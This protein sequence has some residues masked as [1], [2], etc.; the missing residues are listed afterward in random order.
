MFRVDKK[1]LTDASLQ[2]TGRNSDNIAVVLNFIVNSASVLLFFT[3][4]PACL[5]LRRLL[6][7]LLYLENI[8]NLFNKHIYDNYTKVFML[9]LKFWSRSFNDQ[10]QSKGLLIAIKNKAMHLRASLGY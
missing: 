10:F 8:L 3:F 5:F 1:V 4:K 7:N 6:Y 9:A 2:Q